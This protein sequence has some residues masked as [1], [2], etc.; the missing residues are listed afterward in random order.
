MLST[1]G[2]VRRP[3]FTR[4]GLVVGLLTASLPIVAGAARSAP[5]CPSVKP[6][7]LKFNEPLFI[8]ENRAGG[9]P[10]SQVAQDGSI[11][12]SAHAGT[13]HVYKDP[14]AVPG[15]ADF[16][17][18]YTN[19][20]LNWRSTDGGDTWQYVGLAGQP[21]GPHS[22]T[23]TGFSDPD[24]TM[25]AG[26][27]IYNTEIDLAN[28]AVFSSTDDGQ[29]WPYG[30]PEITPG[31]RP[32]L[33]GQEADEVFLYVRSLSP[34]ALWRSTDGGI[35]FTPVNQ[36]IPNDGGKL[37]S[38]PKNPKSGLISP[39]FGGGAGISA[40]DGAT[41]KTYPGNLTGGAAFFPIIAADRKG[42]IYSAAAAGYQGSADAESNGKVTFSYFDRKKKRWSPAYEIPTPTG[43]ALWPWMIA[44]DDGRVAVVWYQTL[45]GNPDEF[46]IYAAY[47]MNGHGKR[48]TCSD[49]STKFVPPQ[50]SVV[51]ASGR[52]IH[53]GE[54]CLSGT[55]CNAEA[56]FQDGDRRLGDFFTVN[57]DSK[58][59]I[60]IASADTTLTSPTEG[61]KPVANPIFIK[62][63]RGT[64]LLARPDETRESRCLFP[65]PSC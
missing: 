57:F 1:S 21:A 23:S 64:R 52:P 33:T 46:Y 62:Q 45:A 3:G 27:R 4:I 18:G 5:N 37:L 30:N 38:D 28:I 43:D 59:N 39:L 19:Q 31:D 20:T 14:T 25:D 36:Q 10:V 63:K 54:I 12:V 56:D 11:I 8:D 29:S 48:V 16:L 6:P 47:T 41:W 50:W 61:P 58:G 40:D 15:S 34:A 44:G 24:L 53:V 65:L 35:T 42:T 49:G 26:G 7:P 13:T 9:E 60:F 22:P 55:T 51:N 2:R 17:V 32:W